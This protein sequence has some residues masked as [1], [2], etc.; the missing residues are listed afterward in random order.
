MK[1]GPQSLICIC[2][3]IHQITFHIIKLSYTRSHAFPHT[4]WTS[5][6]GRLTIAPISR[7][8]THTPASQEEPYLFFSKQC[9]PHLLLNLSG[10]NGKSGTHTALARACVFSAS[11]KASH[12]TTSQ[13]SSSAT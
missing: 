7:T 6:D 9:L 1:M 11:I 3:L 10:T 8:H 12:L 4:Y 2:R 5:H 13:F